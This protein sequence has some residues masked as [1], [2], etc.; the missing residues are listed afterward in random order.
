MTPY[1]CV[2]NY[3]REDEEERQTFIRINHPGVKPIDVE[4]TPVQAILLAAD[5]LQHFPIGKINND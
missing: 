3:A 5:L 4:I 1:V 2:V